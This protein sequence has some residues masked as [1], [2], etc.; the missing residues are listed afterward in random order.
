M[1]RFVLLLAVLSMPALAGERILGEIVSAAGA[2]TTNASTAV[3]FAIPPNTKF[4]IA[5]NAAANICTSSTTA[6]TDIGGAN[7]GLPVVAR[8]KLP[9][10]TNAADSATVAKRAVSG[11]PSVSIVAGTKSSIV[12]IFGA[13]AVTCTVWSRN[14]NE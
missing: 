5:C 6:C 11:S 13:A 8:E 7:P 2:D 14:G 10:S 3:P 1:K 12:R 4:T 9:Q